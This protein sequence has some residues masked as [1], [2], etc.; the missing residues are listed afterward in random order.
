LDLENLLA[1]KPS[2]QRSLILALIVQRL[3]F[4]CSKLASLRYWQSTTLADE[5]EVG[6]ASSAE[7]YEALD[8]LH[9]RQ[10]AIERKLAQ[11]HLQEG[12]VVL[13]DVSS[14]YYEGHTCP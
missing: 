11:R 1:S 6:D 4:P 13:Y 10:A 7:L 12:S 9:K 2:R 14:S 5:L 8:W 3:L